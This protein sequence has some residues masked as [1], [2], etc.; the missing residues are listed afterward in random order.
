MK[1]HM[2]YRQFKCEFCDYSVTRSDKLSEHL[3]N[4]HGL[5]KVDKLVDKLEVKKSKH[6]PQ[7]SPS[8]PQPT[9][10][11]NL[12]E[13]IQRTVTEAELTNFNQIVTIPSDDGAVESMC[14][15]NLVS[16]VNVDIQIPTAMVQNVPTLADIKDIVAGMDQASAQFIIE[17]SDSTGQVMLTPVVELVNVVEN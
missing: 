4:K 8:M 7:I 15:S 12:F 2:G 1:L 10:L 17:C 14:L 16:D 9:V 6:Y 13:T 11:P 3:N 5:D